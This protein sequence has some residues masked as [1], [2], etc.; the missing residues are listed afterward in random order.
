MDIEHVRHAHAWI[1][2]VLAEEPS[3]V[4]KSMFGCLAVYVDG[5]LQLVLADKEEP[6]NGVMVTLEKE[7]H[8]DIMRELPALAPHPVLGKWLYIPED[9]PQFEAVA[10]RISKLILRHDPRIGVVAKKRRRRD[11]PKAK[12]SKKK[13]AALNTKTKRRR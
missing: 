9:H 7:F 8:I 2:E 4:L 10:D 5:K 6:W 12:I 1:L 13:R 11:K 3:L